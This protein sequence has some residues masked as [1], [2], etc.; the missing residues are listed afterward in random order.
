MKLLFYFFVFLVISFPFA[1]SAQAPTERFPVGEKLTYHITFAHFTDAGFVELQTVARQKIGERDAIHLR[2]RL[3]TTGLVEATLLSLDSEYNSFIAPDTGL[4]LRIERTLRESNAPTDIKR[5]FAENQTTAPTNV[6]DLISAIYQVRTLPLAVGSAFP[7]RIT[8]NN[9]NYDADLRVLRKA[10][11]ST[12]VGAFNAFVIQINVPNNEKYNRFRIQMIVSDDERRLP[13]SFQLKHSNGDIRAELA[14]VQI[15][16]PEIPTPQIIA[17]NPI[18]TPFPSPVVPPRPNPIASPRATP[19]PYVEN[20]P[21]AEDLPFALR[22]K[23]SF[24]IYRR[25]QKIGRI[26]FEITDRK[27][28]YSRD[29]VNL[30]AKIIQSS[31]PLLPAGTAFNS[32]INPESLTPYRSEMRAGGSLARFGDIY[33]FDQDR[34]SVSTQKGKVVEVPVGTYD[35]LSLAYALRAFKI[36]APRDARE[37]AKARDTKAALFFGSTA[38]IVTF[39]FANRETL[40]VSGRKIRALQLNITLGDPRTDALGLKLWLSDD[41]QRLPLRFA[42]NSPLGEIRADLIVSPTP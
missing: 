15:I 20:Q 26:E 29:A 32:Y 17:P 39:K 12:A 22:E 24:D 3:K 23:L 37:I 31:D 6:H 21:L 27:L 16:P 34:G 30:T 14:S 41:A 42:F 33:N 10:T 1:V 40:D 13:I 4:P 28:Y 2:A 25:N 7:L 5:D 18:A 9:Q 36:D 19:K 35:L 38:K 8:E 11:V